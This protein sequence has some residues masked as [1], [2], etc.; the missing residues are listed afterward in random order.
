LEVYYSTG[1]P[2]SKFHAEQAKESPFEFRQIGLD[3]DRKELYR[4]VNE[5]VDKM[6]E[7]GF[8]EE[9][10]GLSQRGFLR[11]LN[12]LN[13]VGYKEMFDYLEGT[14]TFEAAVE[15]MKRN[16]RR[17]A[18][19]QLTWFRADKRIKWM[20]VDETTDFKKLADRIIKLFV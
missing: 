15:L 10:R 4:R 14:T 1:T 3:W 12:A 19:R 8:L 5:R 16:T 20:K 17:F 18:K 13:T 6:L 7:Q 11:T 2:I 9:V